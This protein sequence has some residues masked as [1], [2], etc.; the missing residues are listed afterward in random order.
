MY[1]YA[2]E[3]RFIMNVDNLTYNGRRLRGVTGLIYVGMWKARLLFVL[4]RF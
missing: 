1:E 4:L 2:T 3:C